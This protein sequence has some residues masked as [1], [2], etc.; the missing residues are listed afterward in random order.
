VRSV[1]MMR[2][3]DHDRW[4]TPPAAPAAIVRTPAR[5]PERVVPA[6]I[7]AV[8]AR[9]IGALRPQIDLVGRHLWKC[10]I[11]FADL[12]LLGAVQAAGDG[13]V[14]SLGKYFRIVEPLAAG[15]EAAVAAIAVVAR[16][17]VRI[18]LARQDFEAGDVGA[19]LDIDDLAAQRTCWFPAF[20]LTASCGVT[21]TKWS[22]AIGAGTVAQPPTAAAIEM[23]STMLRMAK[24][25]GSSCCQDDV[26]G[27]FVAV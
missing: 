13:Q 8:V 18:Q 20:W 1:M 14:A 22:P 11:E 24:S 21:L 26:G 17:R 25:P 3:H 23:A 16:P 7:A 19:R 9:V 27:L 2:G 5:T 10:I 15:D 12:V 4:R 6:A